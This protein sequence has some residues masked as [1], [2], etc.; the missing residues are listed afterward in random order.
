[1]RQENGAPYNWGADNASNTDAAL[2]NLSAGTYTL[3]AIAT[4]NNNN[5]EETSINISVRATNTNPPP[6]TNPPSTGDV[7]LYENCNLEEQVLPLV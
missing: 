7:V 2:Q 1:M 3:R 6:P 4:D 5:T